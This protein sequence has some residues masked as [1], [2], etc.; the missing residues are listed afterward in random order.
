MTK[1]WA[2]ATVDAVV[3]PLQVA[4]VSAWWLREENRKQMKRPD[5]LWVI[6]RDIDT[7]IFAAE[8]EPP[9]IYVIASVGRRARKIHLPF[10]TR[11]P[12]P[13]LPRPP[14]PRPARP[15]KFGQ[16]LFE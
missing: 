3:R 6:A 13:A 9:P 14:R 16:K 11:R 5:L 7:V 15:I 4:G 2:A 1:D 8:S 10:M 12:T